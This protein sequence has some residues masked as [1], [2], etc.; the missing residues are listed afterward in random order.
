MVKPSLHP[1]YGEQQVMPTPD[2]PMV[3]LGMDAVIMGR[4]SRDS[5]A[6][7][8]HNIIDHNSRY[9]WSKA[10]KDN[11]GL[12]C[13]KFLESVFNTVSPSE[14][15]VTDNGTNYKK[16]RI[17]RRYLAS[18]NCKL[19]TTSAFHPQTNGMTE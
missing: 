14:Y 4:I 12:T 10:T 7:C 17:F 9:V 6:K 8:I 11:T 15:L 18:K 5:N 19:L 13:Q 2:K 3:T 1:T 16:S